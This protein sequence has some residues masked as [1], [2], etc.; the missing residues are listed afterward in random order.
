[1]L[2]PRDG[3]LEAGL[4][5]DVRGYLNPGSRLQVFGLGGVGLGMLAGS[6][7]DPEAAASLSDEECPSDAMVYAD[8]SGGAGLELR[9]S[10]I[11]ALSG[12]FRVL[13]RTRLIGDLGFVE[14]GNNPPGQI[15]DHLLGVAIGID[16]VG[17][18]DAS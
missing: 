17:Y 2:E 4:S 14:R 12:T 3:V 16:L 8:V 15:G 7:H 10:R 18:F 1:V 11:A 6:E 5:L 13:R 9:L